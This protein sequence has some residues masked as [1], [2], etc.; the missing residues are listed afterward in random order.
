MKIKFQTD[1]H[2][3]MVVESP[4][5]YVKMKMKIDFCIFRFIF[6]HITMYIYVENHKAHSGISFC[7]L[8]ASI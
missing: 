6:T 3:N 1:F 8:Y 7:P 2:S 5:E 4:Y